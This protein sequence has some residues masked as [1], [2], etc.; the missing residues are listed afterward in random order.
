MMKVERPLNRKGSGKLIEALAKNGVYLMSGKKRKERERSEKGKLNPRL[1]HLTKKAKRIMTLKENGKLI[2]NLEKSRVYQMV[3]I[4][5]KEQRSKKRKE[6]LRREDLKRKGERVMNLKE[7]ETEVMGV[8][9]K[10]TIYQM[11]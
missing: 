11:G 6:S 5:K 8:V 1:G 10:S 4:K 7:N 2:E 3:D 9:V